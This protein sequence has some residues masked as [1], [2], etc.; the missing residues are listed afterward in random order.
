MKHSSGPRSRWLGCRLGS[1]VRRG[2]ESR[3]ALVILDYG[4]PV[5]RR[6]R[7]GASVFRSFRDTHAIRWSAAQY[8]LGYARCSR[9]TRS[10]LEL[11]IGTSNFGPDVTYRHG[12]VWAG[13]V[14]H[15]N[16]WLRRRGLADSVTAAGAND[17]EP[18]WRGP[19]PTRRWV[20][21][22]RSATSTPYYNY[23]GAAG[24]PPYPG[25]L[26]AWTIEDVW[27]VSWGSGIALP[28]PEIYAGSGINAE[29]W[30]RLGLYSVRAHGERMHFAGAMSQ[31]D[32][33]ATS[34]D[35]CTGVRNSPDKAWAQLHHALNRDPRTAQPLRWATDI[36][37]RS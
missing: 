26:G 17:I 37:W 36:T 8:A 31:L 30:Y 15:V 25:C 14:D 1:R 9:G 13:M 24:C 12:R 20:R 16:W 2:I 5:R 18:G 4:M 6:G 10:H 7:F 34:D 21:G 27:W 23:G 11:G 35:P 22:Y 3:D 33:C 32:S 28:L 29:Q 19:G